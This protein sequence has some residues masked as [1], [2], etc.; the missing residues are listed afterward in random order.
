MSQGLPEA[1]YSGVKGCRHWTSTSIRHFR[2]KGGDRVKGQR[3]GYVEGFFTKHEFKSRIL[4]EDLFGFQSIA[5]C[6]YI[7]NDNRR[8]KR[9]LKH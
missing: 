4:D 1:S 3:N 5:N 6:K 8:V 7:V 2:W 9:F